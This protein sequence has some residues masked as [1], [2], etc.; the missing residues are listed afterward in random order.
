MIFDKL[1]SRRT[2]PSESPD[3]WP[4]IS[5]FSTP[6]AGI[7][8]CEDTA[9]TY[10]AVFAC[11][12][13]I[14]ES[15][16][17]LPWGVFKQNGEIRERA[18][19]HPVNRILKKQPNPEMEPHVFK[20]LAT[21]Q[22]LLWGAHY[23]E[24]EFNGM[25]EP[26]ALWPLD[27]SKM[28]VKRDSKNRIVYFYDNKTTLS[29][30]RVFRVLG[31]TLDGVTP[32]SVI[33][34]ARESISTGLAA[35]SYGAAFFGNGA[36]PGGYIQ[37]KEGNK[38]SETGVKNL[39]T[40]WNRQ[41]KGAR[42]ASKVQYLDAGMEFKQIS[43]PPEDAQFLETRKFQILEICRWFRMPPHKLADLERAHHSNIESQNIEFVTDTLMPWIT[44]FEES[45]NFRLIQEEDHYTKFNLNAL[46]RGDTA[47]RSQFY[48]KMFDRGVLS[49]DEI[50]SREDQNPLPNN[51]GKLRLVP[52]NM[53]SVENANR[54][55]GT[56]QQSNMSQLWRD[57][58]E[59]MVRKEAKALAS[60]IKKGIE[61]GDLDA[62]YS[63]HEQHIIES[64]TPIAEHQ[65]VKDLRESASW[66][67]I[68]SKS[69][70]SQM[71]IENFE[72]EWQRKRVDTLINAMQGVKHV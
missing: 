49:I 54:N 18:I 14:S 52:L 25:G 58:A 65:G 20:T 62:F 9:L 38:I 8:V 30:D 42:N 55:G 17:C 34:Y 70:L 3:N 39:L 26:M 4:R 72:A 32:C 29:A 11:V 53:V 7:K 67:C 22:A 66:Y 56:V 59:R 64:F 16:A 10:S 51:L 41:N 2:V 69:E 40:S 24:I 13:V 61:N 45:A 33:K 27:P 46:L 47:T 23:S 12:K 37:N 5:F 6:A 71:N 19:D 28:E 31:M 48:E 15:I 60:M 63:R 57:P 1:L 36:I 68:D 50:R 43:I 44:R 35:E 21:I